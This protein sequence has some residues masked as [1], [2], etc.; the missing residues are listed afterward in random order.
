M[1]AAR[2]RRDPRDRS[3]MRRAAPQEAAKTAPVR[4]IA[5]DS[6]LVAV[7][8]DG[9]AGPLTPLDV[10]ALTLGR[11]L[12]VSA[13]HGLLA[14]ILSTDAPSGLAGAG[15]DRVWAPPSQDSD[16]L[17]H[18]ITALWHD[19]ELRRIVAVDGGEAAEVL[20]R[21]AAVTEGQIRTNVAAIDTSGCLCLEDGATRERQRDDAPLLIAAPGRF[22]PQAGPASGEVSGDMSTGAALPLSPPR[23]SVPDAA[24]AAAP[25]ELGIERGD[26]ASL[27]LSEA[28]VVLSAGAGV[29]DWALLHQVAAA[30]GAA[31]GGSRV[32]CDAGLLPR[33]RQVGISGTVIAPRC[34]IAFG[35]SGASQH[36]QGIEGAR[37]VVAVNADP[38]APMIARAD[39]AVVTDTGAV[40]RALLDRLGDTP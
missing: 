40:L 37:K 21:I 14:I 25:V 5:D 23:S 3:T 12:A 4:Q 10:E 19:L 24:Q 31:V 6:P 35:I 11:R 33:G 22:R 34:Y 30:L 1:S 29:S 32:V 2:V 15:V 16:A 17:S 28:D 18:Q 39:L 20:R 36:L 38:H 27:P 8:I 7:L 26:P 9:G 13:G